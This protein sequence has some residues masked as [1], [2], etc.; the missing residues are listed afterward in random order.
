MKI[1]KSI[2]QLIPNRVSYVTYIGLLLLN[3]L[4]YFLSFQL[5]IRNLKN[6]INNHLNSMEKVIEDNLRENQLALKRMGNR[7]SQIGGTPENLWRYDAIS[8]SKDL[9]GIV[10]V[11]YADSNTKIK[12]VEPIKTN[13]SAIGFQL[14]SDERR[15][16]AINKAININNHVMTLPINLKQGGRGYLILYPVFKNGLNDGFVYLVGR[17]K[18]YFPNLLRDNNFFYQVYSGKELVYS[19]NFTNNQRYEN[20]SATTETQIKNSID[21]KIKI[22]PTKKIYNDI[23]Y[24]FTLWTL[25]ITFLLSIIIIYILYLY[26]KSQYLSNQLNSQNVWKNAILNNTDLAVISTDKNGYLVS[27]NSAAQK[28]LGYT[29]SELLGKENPML[30]HDEQEVLNYSIQVFK[31]LG[32]KIKPGFDVIVAKSKIGYTEKNIWTIISKAG[33]RKQAFVS[34]Y[35]LINKKYEIEGYVEILEKLTDHLEFEE[36]IATKEILINSMLENTFD[37]F[38]DWNLKIDYQYMSPKFWE[39]LGHNPSEKKHHPSEWQKVISPEGLKLT[40]ENFEKH[41]KSKGTYLFSQE[42]LFKHKDGHDVWILSKG[43]VVDWDED[44]SPIRAIGTN[45]DISEIKKKNEIIEKTQKELIERDRKILE[46]KNKTED[47][48]RIITNSLPQLMWTCEPDGPCD[49]LSEQ[50]INYTGIPEKEQLGF[51]WLKQIHPEDQP[52]VIE[53]WQKNVVNEKVFS[54]QFRIRRHDGIYNWFDTKAIPIK[55]SNQ[56]II[57]WLGSNTNVQELYTIQETLEKAKAEA[58]QSSNAKAQFLANM[59]HEIRTPING[60]LGLSQLLKDTNLDNIQKEYL[61]HINQSGTMLLSL[62]N[63]ILDL[64]KIESGKIE[65]E[66]IDFNLKDTIDFV[67]GTLTYS[68]E[69]K[70]LQLKTEYESTDKLWLKGDPS[71]IKQVLLNF[72]NNAIK[73]T[74]KGFVN[75]R[76]KVISQTVKSQRLRVEVIDT[77]IG[78][79]EENIPKLFHKFTQS[80]SST[81][82][83]FGGT[84]LGL[85]ISKLL[86]HKMG[87]TIGLESKLGVGSTFWFELELPTGVEKLN[88]HNDNEIIIE[89]FPNSNYKILVAEDNIINQK[90]TIALLKKLGYESQVVANGFEVLSILNTIQCDLILM[91]CQMPE[92]DGFEATEKI[93]NLDSNLKNIPIIAMTANAMEGDRERCIAVGMNDYLTKPVSIKDLSLTLNKWLIKEN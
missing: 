54:I 46:L 91:D 44:G 36:L 39:M 57:R 71:R 75:I 52:R 58:L 43:K 15:R 60:I 5:G 11:G 49:Y 66:S 10:G 62:I 65:I 81:H 76:T 67:L 86:V 42:V 12:W 61:E 47:W 31:E 21:W 2:K 40:L 51:E 45:T 35:P 93:R 17:Y 13:S 73:F 92:M 78:I 53:E 63:D 30:W 87:G 32:V 1:K 25:L 72:I 37:G 18:D 29:E 3:V 85:S 70:G 38:W 22:T 88:I 34:I 4:A 83:K 55:D 84:G 9:L 28:M 24:L 50:W 14:N 64:S 26:N 7:W 82:R 8:Y 23:I 56:N 27:F 68:A 69:N 59:S 74:E 41:V 20:L 80:D 79:A 90:V 77:G 89:K 33:I 6:D 48:F 19:T 16:I